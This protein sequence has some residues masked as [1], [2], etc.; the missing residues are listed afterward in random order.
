M[1]NKKTFIPTDSS[2]NFIPSED[3]IERAKNMDNEDFKKSEAYKKYVIPTLK[4]EK[5]CK[6]LQRIDWWK[7]NWVGITTLIVS[8]LTLLATVLIGILTLMN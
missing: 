8:L 1:N 3:A 4:R 2:S 5:R 7:N 6:R